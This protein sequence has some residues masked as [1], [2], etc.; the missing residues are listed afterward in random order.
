MAIDIAALKAK[1]AARL[2]EA[3]IEAATATKELSD[4]S[5]KQ[6]DAATKLA[7][8]DNGQD[9]VDNKCVLG[10]STADVQSSVQKAVAQTAPTP[11]TAADQVLQKIDDL[12]AALQQQL[13]NYESLLHFIHVEL[14]KNE[15]VVHLLTP[16][17]VGIVVAGLSKKKNVVI[18]QSASKASSAR[19]PQGK[20]IKDLTLGDL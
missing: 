19:T 4:E 2:A 3:A 12:Q 20:K 17:Q 14:H 8:F 6:E 1:A 7:V 5:T 18:A 15:D 11:L 9:T 13:P 16:E 10:T